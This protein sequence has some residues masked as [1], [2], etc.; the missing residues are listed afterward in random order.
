MKQNNLQIK[1]IIN[2][3]SFPRATSTKQKKKIHML[4]VPYFKHLECHFQKTTFH[5]GFVRLSKV[6][7][8][9]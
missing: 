4:V 2:S 5:D 8:S 7:D 6:K 1:Q 9:N 3:Q